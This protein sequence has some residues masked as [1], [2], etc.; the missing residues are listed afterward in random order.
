MDYKEKY[1]QALE[2]AKKVKHDAETIGCSMHPDMLEVIFPELAESEDERIRDDIMVAVEN[3]HTCER[4]EEIRSY[5]RKQKEQKPVEWSKNDTAFL[6]DITDF[7]ENKTVRLQ[8]DL[9][10]YAHW[11]KNL[12]ERFVPQPKPEWSAE[13]ECRREGI[14]QWL[15]E[16]QKKFNPEYDSLSI[17]SIESL[18]DWFKSLRPSWKPSEVHLCALL[19][20]LNDPNNIGSQTCQLALTDLHEQLKKL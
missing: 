10:M 3:W 2:T 7:F 17:E 19:A 11:L 16:Y 8:H 6:N 13:D 5:L 18:I 20:I 12:P 4:V 15:R 1:E 9:D 14:I